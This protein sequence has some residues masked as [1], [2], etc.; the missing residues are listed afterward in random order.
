MSKIIEAID[1]KYY[2]IKEYYK[3]TKQFIWRKFKHLN[4]VDSMK[5]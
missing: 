1:E 5:K 4:F 2:D 3:F